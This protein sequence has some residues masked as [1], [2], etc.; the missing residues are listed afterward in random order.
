METGE[1]PLMS[2]TRPIGPEHFSLGPD[3]PSKS[4]LISGCN[5]R[6]GGF[7]WT[8][9]AAGRAGVRKLLQAGLRGF[10]IRTVRILI[11]GML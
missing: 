8:L 7:P 2:L 3:K 6:G 1:A 5:A 9:A 11:V 10:N 4:R